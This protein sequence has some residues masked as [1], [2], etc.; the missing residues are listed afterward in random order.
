MRRNGV[1]E[2]DKRVYV[3]E[4]IEENENENEGN[5]KNWFLYRSLRGLTSLSLFMTSICKNLVLTP[6]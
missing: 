4:S 6:L 2:N 1:N 5:E 3:T